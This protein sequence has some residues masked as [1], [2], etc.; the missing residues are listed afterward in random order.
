MSAE[1]DIYD[2]FT[3][4]EDAI[5]AVFKAAEITC[6]TPLGVQKFEVDEADTSDKD[7]LEF[8]KPRPRVEVVL[9]P[10]SNLGLLYPVSG[11]RV[12][13]GHLREQARRAMLTLTIVTKDSI[14]EHRAF[15]A[16]VL[17]I[18]DTL[19][20]EATNSRLLVNHNLSSLRCTGGTAGYRPQDGVMETLLNFDLDFAVQVAAFAAL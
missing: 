6:L 18:A 1:S 15:V 3:P 10:G 8:Q 16:Q 11:R 19:A 4:I 20:Y 5:A 17:Y 2:Y 7:A 9:H 13:A 14:L 12:A